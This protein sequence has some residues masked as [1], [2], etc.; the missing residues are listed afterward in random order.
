[1]SE[2]GD[3]KTRVPPPRDRAAWTRRKSPVPAILGLS[4][5]QNRHPPD[6]V[7]IGSSPSRQVMA[8]EVVMLL[9]NKST[10]AT[11]RCT[12]SVCRSPFKVAPLCWCQLP[13]VQTK[14]D[15]LWPQE[16]AADDQCRPVYAHSLPSLEERIPS[17]LSRMHTIFWSADILKHSVLPTA[18]WLRPHV[19]L[20]VI[21][22]LQ[23][24]VL[25]FPS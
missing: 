13:S 11:F 8:G 18:R 20:F 22:F 25:F 6:L 17:P 14:T 21:T 24:A 1:M 23:V 19:C 7:L 10:P 9:P 4:I 16:K 5:Q 12:L 2:H 15:V 3:V